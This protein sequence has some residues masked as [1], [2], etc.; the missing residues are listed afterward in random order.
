MADPAAGHRD[1]PSTVNYQFE[2]LIKAYRSQDRV[3]GLNC[4]LNLDG[5]RRIDV[6]PSRYYIGLLRTNS[7]GCTTR[8]YANSLVHRRSQGLEALRKPR[9]ESLSER[10]KNKASGKE[11]KLLRPTLLD[12]VSIKINVT[13]SMNARRALTSQV[14]SRYLRLRYP[15][16]SQAEQA[17]SL[18]DRSMYFKNFY[19]FPIPPTSSIFIILHCLDKSKPLV[20]KML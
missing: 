16:T 8:D 13:S 7:D 4:R 19:N 6:Q 2:S 5:G 18:M 10:E 3:I 12:C 1:I 17:P 11:R 20:R 9:G 15:A 14:P